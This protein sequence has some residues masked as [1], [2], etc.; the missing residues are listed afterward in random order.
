[1]LE[2]H[3]T[4]NNT[5]FRLG[6]LFV[7][8]AFF[9]SLPLLFYCFRTGFYVVVAF[10]GPIIAASMIFTIDPRAQPEWS[11][12]YGKW[13]MDH[14]SRYF[15]LTVKMEDFDAVNDGGPC[16]FALEPHDVLPVS[17]FWGRCAQ[18]RV[19]YPNFMSLTIATLSTF[20]SDYL[21]VLPKHKSFGCMSGVLF[22]IPII[23]HVYTW[24]SAASADRK[25]CLALLGKGHP[26]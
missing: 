2:V 17:I 13:T 7:L 9:V 18:I 15:S 21:K 16:L 22:R 4:K 20:K 19:S 8:P 24:M 26:C 23:R 6:W 1:M 10:V 3:L 25:N 14:A 5:H 11:K 12:S